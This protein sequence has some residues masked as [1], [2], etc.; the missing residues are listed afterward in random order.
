[1][2]FS[3]SVVQWESAFQVPMAV[4]YVRWTVLANAYDVKCSKHVCAKASTPQILFRVYMYFTTACL[5]QEFM[6]K[7]IYADVYSNYARDLKSNLLREK[8]T[9]Q[10]FSSQI[11]LCSR[12]ACSKPESATF[13]MKRNTIQD[14]VTR[15]RFCV[16]K[17]MTFFNTTAYCHSMIHLH[18][19]LCTQSHTNSDHVQ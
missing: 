10:N 14:N 17:Y 12:Q 9:L 4:L 15:T 2:L 6:S 5:N 3:Q 18:H 8:T 1:M 13:I 16:N 19:D 7:P 11:R